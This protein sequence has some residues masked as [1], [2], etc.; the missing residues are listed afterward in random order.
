MR[1]FFY[2][3]ERIPTAFLFLQRGPETLHERERDTQRDALS[4]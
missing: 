2:P 1:L 3:K 4:E